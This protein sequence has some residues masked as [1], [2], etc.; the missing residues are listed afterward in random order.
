MEKEKGTVKW[1]NSSKG[2]G[3]ISRESG[4]GDVFVHHNEIS[5]EMAQKPVSV[6]KWVV[7]LG[8]WH[9]ATF[10]PAVQHFGNPV[11]N[12][13]AFTGHFYWIQ[14]LHVEIR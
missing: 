13:A 1:F 2:Y 10:E 9:S 8:K 3:F 4:D 11:H 5:G 6:F 7:A 14:K 12:A